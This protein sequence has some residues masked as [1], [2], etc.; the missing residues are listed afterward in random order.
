MSR[1][2]SRRQQQNSIPQQKINND[3]ATPDPAPNEA[4]FPQPLIFFALAAEYGGLDSP[5]GTAWGE[6]SI[7]PVGSAPVLG[8]S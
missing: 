6:P 5:Q 4:H 3:A 2:K 8:T 1:R 7:P